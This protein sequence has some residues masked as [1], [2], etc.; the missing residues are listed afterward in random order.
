LFS[1]T[2]PEFAESKI[3]AEGGEVWFPFFDFVD[4]CINKFKYE[5]EKFYSVTKVSD[6][7]LNDLFRITGHDDL[8][9]LLLAC[10]DKLINENQL[11]PLLV[12]SSTPFV[13]FKLR[14]DFNL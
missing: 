8:E 5:I 3:L 2:L 9:A 14:D 4:E 12:Y 6:P 7:N 13:C 11:Q 10:P 1:R